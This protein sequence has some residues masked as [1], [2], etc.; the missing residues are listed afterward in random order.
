MSA[1]SH[2]KD[3]HDQ[4]PRAALCPAQLPPRRE[5]SRAAA[6]RRSPTPKRALCLLL[7]LLILSQPSL[8]LVA[9]TRVPGPTRP[10]LGYSS[11]LGS[12]TRNC[13]LLFSAVT[14]RAKD[15]LAYVDSLVHPEVK[16][17]PGG[18]VY[19][20]DAA[21]VSINPPTVS[22]GSVEGT[23]R[24]FARE[25]YSLADGF[26]LSGDLFAASTP[27]VVAPG[28]SV[29]GGVASEGR[30]GG[31][32]D[33]EIALDGG[34]RII[35]SVHA[36]AETVALP[37]DIPASMPAP[38]GTR[39]VNV[40]MPDDLSLIA[41][42][43][44][45][46]DFNVAAPGLS[47]DVPPG[48]YRRLD[49]H[50]PARL[51]F[52][53]G[54]YNFSE[55]LSVSG[56]GTV[57]CTGKV[58]VNV[59]QSLDVRAGVFMPGAQTVPGDVRLNVLGP[60][61]RLSEGASVA[62]LVRAPHAT[63]EVAAD[64]QVR[65]QVIAGELRLTGGRVAAD[66]A[67]QAGVATTFFGPR[68]FDRKNGQ[69][70]TETERFALPPDTVGPFTLT[71][72][73]GDA[74]GS[75]RVS[76]TTIKLNGAEIFKQSDFN[77]NVPSLSRTVT[78]AASNTLE[79]TL[80]S[81][82]G[83]FIIVNVKG[84]RLD[85]TPPLLS[86]KSPADGLTTNDAA[87]A[88]VSGTASDPGTDAT[89]ISA[90]YV[91][92]KAAF[93]DA[94]AGNW[95][96]ANLPLALGANSITVRAVD[97]AGNQAVAKLTVTRQEPPRDTIP[98][99]LSVNTPADGSMTEATSVTVSGTVSD[100]GSPASGVAQVTVNGVASNLDAAAGTWS[101]AN[102]ALAL[103]A[104]TLTV[105]ATDKAGNDV[106]RAVTVTRVQ[107]PPPPDTTAPLLFVASPQDKLVTPSPAVTV[108]GTAK[109][110][111]EGATG[112]RRV[113]VNGREASLD[114][115][116]G[117]WS[118]ADVPL[119]EGVN[120]ISVSAFDGAPTPN[121][122]DA[123]VTVT[124]RTPDT[125]PPAVTITSPADKAETF[126]ASVAVSGT[127]TDE[128]LNAAGVAQVVVNGQE[129]A[130]DLVT[131]RWTAPNVLLAYGDNSIVVVA[132]DGAETPNQTRAEIHVIRAK[133]DPPAL[134]INSPQAD[135]LTTF[136][137]L[138]VAGSVSSRAPGPLSVTV[139]G[140][141]ASVT[142]EQF[143]RVAALAEGSNTFNVVATD[144]L[145]QQSQQSVSLVADLTPPTVAFVSV[146]AT[147]LPGGSY[148]V[149]AEASDNVGL[150]D[151]EFRVNG[152]R[153]AA[154]ADAP[155]RFTLDVPTPLAAGNILTLTAVA[156]DRAGTTAVATAQTRTT[157]PGAVS[158]YAFDD[159]TGYTLPGVTPSLNGAAGAASDESGAFNLISSEPSGV[160]RV[161]KDGYTPVERLYS[162]APGEGVALFDA[163]LT[164]LD[165]GQ[166]L[167]GAAGG[168]AAGDGGRLQVK[169]AA[170]AFGADTD[171][172][173][174]SV[175]P[176][177]LANLLPFGWSPVPGAVVDVRPRQK[178][179]ATT[180]GQPALLTVAQTPGLR[181]GTQLILARYD[182]QRHGW[183][184]A[185]AGVEAG[186]GGALSAELSDFGQYAFIV[187]DE[188][189][190]APP[191]VAA[192]QPLTSSAPPD[193][194]L[195]D[196]AKAVAMTAPR[197]LLFSP[198]ASAQVLFTATATR[199]L[200]SGVS[201]QAR[202][203][204]TYN[205]LAGRTPSLIER[206]AQDFVLYAFPA[207]S[208][209]PN[210]LAASF[211]A[212]PTRT[213][214]IITDLLNA[215]IHVEIGSGGRA[216][217]GALI[218]A[219]GGEV[220]AG[221]GAQ[222]MLPAGALAQPRP[223]FFSDVAADAA[224]ASL[225]DGYE[226]LAAYDVD[227]TGATLAKAAA[228]S[229]P[230]PAGDLTR[231]VVARLITV[232]GRRSPKVVA[233]AAEESGRLV[234]SVGATDLGLV[235]VTTSGRYLL[236]RVPQPF[237]FVKGSVTD[238]ASGGPQAS[239]RV[240]TDTTPFI[241]I[242]GPDGRYLLVGAAGA[243]QLAAAALDTDATGAASAALTGQD[244]VT[245]AALK[246][247]SVPLAVESV[248]PAAGAQN[249][250]VTS[251]VTVTFNKP[252]AA[253]SVTASGLLLT[254]AG[255]DP[256]LG[257][258]TVSA[259]GRAAV[260][261]PAATLG[262]A[263]AYKL[264]VGQTIRDIYGKPLA[265]AF[266]SSFTTAGTVR[267]ADRLNAEKIRIN[268]PDAAG[269][270]KISIPAGAVPEGSG[271][272]ALDNASGSTVST[273]AGAAPLELAIQ[274]QVGDE[275][276][277]IVHQPDD[278]E[279]RVSQGAYRGPEGFTSVGAPGGTL[280]SDDGGIVLVVPP[281]AITGL[282]DIRLSPQKE[283][284]IPIPRVAPMDPDNVP[285][286]AGCLIETRG[287]FR[288]EKEL[289]LEL[290]AP[291][292]LEEGQRVI[293]LKPGKVNFEGADRDVWETVTSG[294]VEGGRFKTMSAPFIG[295][296]LLAAVITP[297]F[298]FTPKKFYAV[299]GRVTERVPEAPS[300][301]LPGLT[302]YITAGPHQQPDVTA[303]TNADG[304]FAT[305][306]FRVASGD[307]VK[308]KA[309]DLLN[310][311][312]QEAVA[313]PQLNTDP[314]T[315]PG[316]IGIKSS[317]ATIEFPSPNEEGPERKPAL[318]QLEGKMQV[319]DANGN[320][321]DLPAGQRDTL[322]ELGLV[323]VG[324]Y[325]RLRATTTPAVQRLASRTVI[326]SAAGNLEFVWRQVN[327]PIPGT[328]VWERVLNVND[329]GSYSV[330][331][332]SQTTALLQQS[333]A[334]ASFNF[335]ALRNPN[336]RPPLEGPPSVL[337]VSPADKEKQVDAVSRV[338]LEFSE[339]VKNLIPG[340]TIYLLDDATGQRVGGQLTSGGLPVD[341]DTENISSIDF[342]PATPLAGGKDY[343]V[344]VT[345][346]VVDSDGHAFDQQPTAGAAPHPF[347]S[348]FRTF[349]GLVLTKTPQ[350]DLAYRIASAG[351]Y[352]A[353]VFNP[354]P[355]GSFLTVYDM[356]DPQGPK[357]L[358]STYVPQ[359]SIGLAMTE[360]PKEPFGL[361]VVKG[362]YTRVAVVTTH[363]LP[364]LTRATNAWVYDV[365]DPAKPEII[366]VCSLTFP[367]AITSIPGTVTI[368]GKRAY[369][370]TNTHGGVYVVDLEK[371]IIEWAQAKKRAAGVAL[372]SPQVQA[373]APNQ[374]FDFSARV[375]SAP[376][377]LS[378]N[379]PSPV[380][381]VSV[382]EQTVLAPGFN[383][384][385]TKMPVAYVGSP[386]AGQ[387][388]SFGFDPSA[389]NLNGLS[390]TTASHGR[391]QRLL[392]MKDLNPAGSVLDVRAVAGVM[393]NGRSTDLAVV[394]G[395]D[396]LWLFDVTTP[397]NPK[398]LSSPTF[399]DLGV[400]AGYARHMEVEGTTAY[401][402]FADRVA[403]FDFSDPAHPA[404][405]AT[406]SGI[407]GN[408]LAVTAQGG[409]SYT[410]SQ[411]RGPTDGLNVEVGR[412]ASQVVVYGVSA[413][414]PATPTPTPAAGPTPL[415]TPTQRQFC[416]NP[417]VID[418]LR[419]EMQQPAGVFFQ[420]FGHDVPKTAS[421]VIR[422][423]KDVGGTLKQ[424]L[425]TTL[426]ANVD[427][428][429]PEN[430]VVGDAEWDDP[431]LAIDRSYTYTAEV[432]LDQG[433]GK[434]EYHSKPEP[435]PFSFLIGEAQP[436]LGTV[437]IP[438]P[439]DKNPDPT[440]RRMI[441]IGGYSYVLAGNA[442]VQLVI[443][444]KN[445]LKDA[446]RPR[447]RPYGLNSDPVR[448]DA[449]DLPDG[450]Y[451]FT[452]RATLEGRPGVVDEVEGEMR[453][454]SA[455][456][457]RLPGGGVVNGVE[458]STGNLALSYTDAEIKNRGLSLSLTRSYNTAGA[459][460]FNPFGYGWT[461]NYQVLLSFSYSL[462]EPDKRIFH[463]KG[464]DG[465]GQEFDERF[466]FPGVIAA[467]PPFQGMLYTN[468]DGSFDYFTKA[469]VK[470]HF[471]GALEEGSPAF[472]NAGYMGN[473]EY[474]EEPNGNRL[475]LDYDAQGR[476]VKVSDSS[477][478]SLNFTY[479]QAESPFTGLLPPTSP[480]SISCT[481]KEQFGLVR[482]R[483]IKADIGKAWRISQVDGPGGLTIEYTY[484]D[485]GNLATATRS[486]TDNI[487]DATDDSTWKYAY[488]P[489]PVTQVDPK[490]A[491]LLREVRSPNE[492]TAQGHVTTYD[493]YLN[494]FGLPVR[495]ISFPEQQITNSFVY[496]FV[497]NRIATAT[498]VDGRAHLTTYEFDDG[499]RP[500]TITG[501][502][503]QGPNGQRS[504]VT[505][506][507]WNDYGQ[508]EVETDPELMETRTS[509]DA[510]HNPRT[511]TVASPDG[512]VIET[513][514]EYDQT[515]A[516]P[517][518]FVDGRNYETRYTIDQSTGNVTN[519]K[520]PTSREI[521]LNYNAGNGD[522]E[523]VVDE[524]GFTTTYHYDK[525][526]NPM[527]IE[528][529]TAR[530]GDVVV[531]KNTYDDRSRLT[532]TES[533][534]GPTITYS[535]DA[536]DRVVS[537]T[538]T[539]P[540]G[541]RDPLTSTYDYFPG[542]QIK[543]ATQDGGGQ[544]LKEE[545][546][547]D[548]MDR[549]KTRT[550]TP[551][552]AGPFVLKYTYDKNS[553]PETET[554]RRGV[555]LTYTYDELNHKTSTTA[556]GPYGQD[557]PV[558]Q[559]TPDLV[560]DPLRVVNLYG[561]AVENTFDGLHRL[562]KRKLPGPPPDG[563]TEEMAYDRANNVVSTKDRN[564]R[565]TTY[566]YDPVN[567]PASQ[568]DP[569]K[570][571][572]TWT[573]DDAT[574][575]VRTEWSPQ[576]M[577]RTMQAD[578]LNR[579][580]RT[581]VK[582]TS[583]DYVTSY[584]YNGR[585]VQMTD[586]RGTVTTTS[587]SAFNDT[588]RISVAGAT[589]AFNTEAHFSAFGGTNSYTDANGRLTSYTLDGLNRTTAVSYQGGFSES[590][591]Y[592]G[593]GNAL[594]H[595]D[596][597]GARSEMT[598]DNVGRPLTTKTFDA[599]VGV[600]P[601]MTVT[602]ADAASAETWTDARGHQTLK[603]YDGLHRLNAVTN[604]DGKR[605]SY[606]YDG[607]DLRQ[608]TDFKGVATLY[609]YD[610]LD[611]LSKVT[612][613]DN[614]ITLIAHSDLGG[615]T[616]TT[617]D[618]RSTQSV[619]VYDPLGRLTSVTYG[620]EPLAA[621]DYDGN[622]NRTEMRDGLGNRTVYTYDVL[623]RLNTADH[624]SI[625]LETYSYDGVGNVVVYSGGLGGSVTR[626]YDELD[627]PTSWT[628]GEGDTTLF[629]YDGEGLLLEQTDPKGP[630]YKTVYTY[631]ALRSLT[632]V[633]DAK[634]GVWTFDYYPD[635]TLMT[636]T[637]ALGRKV[638][639]DYDPVRRP[640][641]V[642][643]QAADTPSHVT[644]Y[645][646][647]ANSNRELI[648][649]PKGQ[650]SKITYDTMDRAHVMEYSN[651]GGAGPRKYVYDYDPE[652]NLFH[653]DET[654]S[655]SSGTVTRGYGLA[656]DAR[657]RLKATTDPF[658]HTVT[659]DYD[660][661]DNLITLTD[662]AK[663]KTVYGYDELNRIKTVTLPDGPVVG[664]T[665][666]PDG[667]LE[668]VTYD[669]GLERR[670]GYDRADRL[671]SVTNL[672]G[673]GQTEEYLYTYDKNS[674]VET[675]TKKFGGAVFRDVAYGYDILNR[676]TQVDNT[677]GGT[678]TSSG[679]VHGLKAEYFD[680]ADFTDLKL[681]RID[682]TIDFAWPGTDS[683]DP[684]IDGDTFSAR[685]TGQVMPLYSETYTFY[686]QTDESVRLWVDGKL[687]ID[688]TAAHTSTEDAG[689]ITLEAGKKYDIKMEFSE[690]TGD[691]EARLLWSSDSQEKEVVPKLRLY[692]PGSPAGSG[693]TQT[694]PV[695]HTLNYTYDAVGNRRSEFGE[696]IQGQP[697][698][699]AYT[700]ND[701]NQLKTAT[702]YDGGDIGYS[703]DG[704]GNLRQTTQGGLTTATYEHDVRDQL[705]RVF[706]GAGQEVV[707]YDYDAMRRRLAKTFVATGVESRYV[708]DRDRLINEFDS[709][710]LDP[711]RFDYGSDLLCSDL[712]TEGAR[713]HFTDGLGS[714][715]ALS[716]VGQGSLAARY[717]Y[718]A[719]GEVVTAGNSLNN[720]GYTGQRLDPETGLL[721]LGH[722]ERYYAAGLGQFIQ[723]DSWTGMAMMA[724]STNRYAYVSNNPLK[725][726]DPS[727]H[728]GFLA[729]AA[730]G[731]AVGFLADAA[732]QAI[733]IYT[734]D[735]KLKD[736]SVS[737]A[738]TAGAIGAAIGSGVY[739]AAAGAAF[740][741]GLFGVEG[742]AAA[743]LVSV[744]A[745][746]GFS[747]V[748]LLSAGLSWKDGHRARAV[749][750]AGMAVAPFFFKSV[751]EDFAEF[752]VGKYTGV[753]P[754]RAG[755]A[756]PSVVTEGVRGTAPSE[757]PLAQPN[758]PVGDN[759]MAHSLNPEEVGPVRGSAEEVSRATG[760]EA[761]GI[762]QGGGAGG[763]QEVEPGVRAISRTETADF[764]SLD[765]VRGSIRYEPLP[766]GA[767]RVIQQLARTKKLYGIGKAPL[768]SG[769]HIDELAAISKWFNVEIGV[770]ESMRTGKLMAVLGER[771][772]VNNPD[773]SEY[774][775]VAHTHPAFKSD[776]GPLGHF[777]KDIPNSGARVEAVIDWSGE[778]TH[779]N[780]TGVLPNPPVSPI[781]EYK[782][783]V[784]Y[785]E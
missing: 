241:D 499:G 8:S 56:G 754:P 547:Y 331:V 626:T 75:N 202:F 498:V 398:Q 439:D 694:A 181:P 613:R 705:R 379:D 224:G 172:R 743:N 660:A 429:S 99:T 623:N 144:S 227:L 107:P 673:Q 245:E 432:V 764:K 572:T 54:V 656:H 23:M 271:L 558:E 193:P 57:E 668:K 70:V 348:S 760:A 203:N 771:K 701:L 169:V 515:F 690:G 768:G 484:D 389:D 130:Y 733:D 182:E 562:V 739:L 293:F 712:Q 655:D 602:Y 422:R 257:T 674:N 252:V 170:G 33:Y 40:G 676:L 234:S 345:P 616:K 611:R 542:G 210:S 590:F 770:F 125:Q 332:E 338:H 605:K 313:S 550:E 159:S 34:S 773:P 359:R 50:A 267:E 11:P 772:F 691:A 641:V 659:Y 524:Y 80:A 455:P 491:H 742:A 480:G 716:S 420:V 504:P 255:G 646:Y 421:V 371:A 64:S 493:Y 225:P 55:G 747:A 109:D 645:G 777:G 15:A 299:H 409:F 597:R 753:M 758:Q 769:I 141:P 150:A 574:R 719:W 120:V 448:Y 79:V 386:I 598:Y 69:P 427:K 355:G 543:T 728:V 368:F 13:A 502:P 416:T 618:R 71:V 229:L 638:S 637:D 155:F 228:I 190:T 366:G 403:S 86:V 77:Q 621:F 146:P 729:T 657:S 51:N 186:A 393:V 343:E 589:P 516:K 435:V 702:G 135:S 418:R 281:G 505:T 240:T 634:K 473:L 4:R 697:V 751:R 640:T 537:S 510:F 765:H 658:G 73:N 2:D 601:V 567:R 47:I 298:V 441:G 230:A 591:T 19:E 695:T 98:P 147:V 81:K 142:G 336:T 96:L 262:G 94:T 342:E 727:G 741:G 519:I 509:Y 93:Y 242:T 631:N 43:A 387:L 745:T 209:Q 309:V 157:G 755:A 233:R 334:T 351:Q 27:A 256:V 487:S 378:D 693:T 703:Y 469:H 72:Q 708:Y 644:T 231:V 264:T 221:S 565:E 614:K 126:D 29:L 279:Y 454:G 339:P 260:F 361:S 105:S 588:G 214:L 10:G 32:T 358:S 577:T 606:T 261:T 344:F 410:L 594:S 636:A 517:N 600:I 104:N 699:H 275:I 297:I 501:P 205:L 127:A 296:L 315:S 222:L 287:T 49:L 187:A 117:T 52:T 20:N 643:Q 525:Y 604:P 223:V 59:G 380:N 238:A 335:I 447:V 153:V 179:P 785:K 12:L 38:K 575:T 549:L 698:S 679:P 536:L 581:E 148:Q 263:T 666:K 253:P 113:T 37:E 17:S 481:N 678:S 436:A 237:G 720:F 385:P 365:S 116:T 239:V 570:R 329:E 756:S 609:E 715:T 615:H 219:E 143:T 138:T 426:Q 442:D 444:G 692:P 413:L 100:A 580:L 46:G 511:Q 539:D 156:R 39:V 211:V 459:N 533:T 405:L 490:L 746:L 781:N 557:I 585:T 445:R 320:L 669:A 251:P 188:G 527:L 106:T 521:V 750:E 578:G 654:V 304:G 312:E 88:S 7:A 31:P 282:A 518:R 247:A 374:G 783:V 295:L 592:D 412:A 280:T 710:N 102:V 350:P 428:E 180:F 259:G 496:G 500:K 711:H 67:A 185:G 532:S 44:T 301:P 665:W 464:G 762:S 167:V 686:T 775:Y 14:S 199:Q 486:G 318:L 5:L 140:E 528:R 556:S 458:L 778:I 599:V 129:A 763:S 731:F 173:V 220:R 347:H 647:D 48:D 508:K 402:I 132:T 779:F 346:G 178:G 375:Q 82:P 667:M 353:T 308:V 321:V 492:A 512:S 732:I 552:G 97:R 307:P 101:I 164:P 110:E 349:A 408:L 407:G 18:N 276:T 494:E 397:T 757:A 87:L 630:Q 60:S 573:Y 721:A 248:S 26:V 507:R 400:D 523:S 290:P 530:G 165:S 133:P 201:A 529:E 3:S 183:V 373:V 744:G 270:S 629:K 139:N 112:V 544:T 460:V 316:L 58:T 367:N 278:I 396:R 495:L 423:E 372:L 217:V 83:S 482:N 300:K 735:K 730:I 489:S 177:G 424:E 675:Q 78:L 526:G 266:E 171:L 198:S 488:N 218:G 401:V 42:W 63:V 137:A 317:F 89:G 622:G 333:E 215:N 472:I 497:K 608:E 306:D 696:D 514:T 376:Y 672:V 66:T 41:D 713:W 662:A 617:T 625:Q 391:D 561:Q 381:S 619:E 671:R 124:R 272:I 22:G 62:A 503:V 285:F 196:A 571:V 35:G 722:G 324:S 6:F 360:S 734:G 687:I 717:E 384:T 628:D 189:A 452:L 551:S 103:G 118:A 302:C 624:S 354:G 136:K 431:G 328:S 612:D 681:T 274:A 61:V 462:T 294:R 457:V 352:A 369:I 603:E 108:S 28:G 749:F 434:S 273:V 419:K 76:S 90:V 411:G 483:F 463:I 286:G 704:N 162:V 30:A 395:F 465:S 736:F 74:D 65:G 632:Q 206:P 576:G 191:A 388:I 377:G 21:A 134:T 85:K 326:G 45:V 635:Q 122:A 579:P 471:P 149:V 68:R 584:T 310:L 554:D 569:K 593:E 440:Q 595:T 522:L 283:S 723:Q 706:D 200:P 485:D 392:A 207:L 453:V 356:S 323:P 664:Y 166:N 456:P 738:V 737:E 232:V 648:I 258:I 726:T 670:Y 277:F 652:G 370:G 607:M 451:P 131:H 249:A 244:A 531:T 683:P 767:K 184:V 476:M 430:V 776:T 415:P 168:T 284:D 213:D 265:S 337:T 268:Y 111:G 192:G 303:K 725:Y 610:E 541:F 587:M 25:S 724:Q 761:E 357:P 682:P 288:T 246:V 740:I 538:A 269:L 650:R 468:P 330:V 394:L 564:G 16:G 627:H 478:R 566:G 341:K 689:T 583:A 506:I 477:N 479:E 119:D 651:V 154:L 243:N 752:N 545:Y 709:R 314:Y 194:T 766:S 475:R 404:R 151:V 553:N 305:V 774:Y 449:A 470:Y 707:R 568:T 414:P 748:G 9:A 383:F 319:P 291:P 560:G 446:A 208:T 438:D 289:H 128:G 639:Y 114:A 474:I 176:Q 292:G 382:I 84:T 467:T 235:N 555:T 24:V 417:V 174:T 759:S 406:V 163:R 700:Y 115:T 596:R 160:V 197:A 311:R 123:T 53:G 236:V 520:L 362:G 782:Y 204:E 714:V 563:Y 633:K 642:T 325:I 461:H 226:V 145:G 92:D 390:S 216:K 535:Y 212:R 152:Q 322:K 95:T 364:D 684:S 663:K 91:N 784:G 540:A 327:A 175:S 548:L 534:L 620:N 425:I 36:G 582:F 195:L 649:D 254:T 680:D 586:P 399:L 559:I 363:A 546:A 718:G 780:N 450:L 688:H 158:G 161:T 437:N 466:G 677:A 513:T 1:D 685:W 121:R 661:A 653:A 250:V 433:M 443:N 340:D